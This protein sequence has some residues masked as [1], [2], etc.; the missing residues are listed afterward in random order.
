MKLVTP[1]VAI[2]IFAVI[3]VISGISAWA[4]GGYDKYDKGALHTFISILVGL[5]IFITFMFYY[6]L[7]KLQND[8]QEFAAVQETS[9]INDN[10]LNSVLK[11]IKAANL[12]IPKFVDSITPLTSKSCCETCIIGD[13]PLNTETC[14]ERMVLSYRLFSVWQDVISSSGYSN[15]DL[16]SYI[17]NF[18]Q[19]AN[20]E[21]LHEQW[22]VNRL[23]F[24]DKTQQLGDILF[25][26]GLQITDQTP[27][28][29]INTAQKV[30]NDPS[31]KN[32]FSK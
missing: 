2:I 11:E 7:V 10:I 21:Q 19:R 26:Y 16:P 27:E 20:S 29:Y 8:Q 4:L 32:I 25:T 1:N 30:L 12:V 9:R 15:I 28:E 17:A 31:F 23:N 13:D 18:L 5:G 3:L 6:N 24:N 22:L 14:T